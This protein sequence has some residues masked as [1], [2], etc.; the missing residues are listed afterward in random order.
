MADETVEELRMKCFEF[1]G[2]LQELEAQR[3]NAL[4]KN[5]LLVGTIAR[6]TKELDDLK[7]GKAP[8]NP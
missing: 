3:N 1:G 8:S 2:R 7:N 6:L 5:V 4:N